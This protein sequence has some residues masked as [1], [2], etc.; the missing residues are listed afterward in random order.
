MAMYTHQV[1]CLIE[2]Q[3]MEIGSCSNSL[4]P[5]IKTTEYPTRF[6]IGMVHHKLSAQECNSFSF[7]VYT[8]IHATIEI[9]TNSPI[10]ISANEVEQDIIESIALALHYDKA[11]IRLDSVRRTFSKSTASQHE[12][13]QFHNAP[14]RRLLLL[15][16]FVA[17]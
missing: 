13:S 6:P 15:S 11:Y 16:V 7:H 17:S 2:S 9:Q 4:E 10:D 12:L 5:T 14:G 1:N 3:C 8:E